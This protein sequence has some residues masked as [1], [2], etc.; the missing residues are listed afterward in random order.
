M[1][2]FRFN[3]RFHGFHIV[4]PA[5][6]KFLFFNNLITVSLCP[7]VFYSDKWAKKHLITYNINKIRIH[8]KIELGLVGMCFIVFIGLITGSWI[9]SLPALFLYQWLRFI[10]LIRRKMYREVFDSSNL[11]NYCKLRKPFAWIKYF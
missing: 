8:Q 5:I 1:R 4:F 2:L 7:F 11:M 6:F 3:T 9:L 10:P